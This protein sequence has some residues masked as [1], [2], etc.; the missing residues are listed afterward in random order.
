MGDGRQITLRLAGQAS[1]VCPGGARGEV[2]RFVRI[3]PNA[4]RRGGLAAIRSGGSLR[5]ELAR[6]L[7]D[8]GKDLG[9]LPP[10]IRAPCGNGGECV[11]RSRG[12]VCAE[13]G[14][15]RDGG[16][17]L[18]YF[19]RGVRSPEGDSGEAIDCSAG[20]IHDPSILIGN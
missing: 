4:L 3:E 17:G 8:C 1:A 15:L 5:T 7:R 16:E 19:G 10:R 13:L 14:S 12:Q 9:H 6:G 20:Y 18:H 11:N 2:E